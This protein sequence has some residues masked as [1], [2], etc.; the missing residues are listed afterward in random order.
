M[1]PP[2]IKL[3]LYANGAVFLLQMAFY[4]PLVTALGLNPMSF[5]NGA[6]WQPFTYM[7]LHGGVW[8]I[9]INMLILWMFGRDLEHDW[10]TRPFIKFYLICGIGAA[11]VTVIF[12]LGQ[13]VTTIGASGAIFGVLLAFGMAYPNRQI[14]LLLFFVLPVT[15]KAKYMVGGIAVLQFLLL[16]EGGGGVSYITHIGGLLTAFLYLKLFRGHVRF[17]GPFAWLGKRR[18]QRKGRKLRK[19][20]D[21]QRDLMEAVDKVLDRI[22]EVGFDQL[23]EEEKR[24]LAKASER[25]SGEKQKN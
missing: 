14:T 10:G 25:L 23:T 8:H 15:M 19:Q 22:N 9:L 18:A 17:S 7:F 11:L 12:Q 2:G 16:S 1:L 24:T 20:W 5:L 21:E 6:F 3:L 13:S 4:E